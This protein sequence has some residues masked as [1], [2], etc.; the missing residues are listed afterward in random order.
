VACTLYP[1]MAAA[2]D[3]P[4]RTRHPHVCRLFNTVAALPVVVGVMGR[5]AEGAGCRVR[6]TGCGFQGVVVGYRFWV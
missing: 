2:L 3:A 4:A 6:G 5:G 1:A